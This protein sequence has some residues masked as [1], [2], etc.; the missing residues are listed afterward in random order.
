[1]CVCFLLEMLS[2]YKCLIIFLHLISLTGF[3]FYFSYS[4]LHSV[5]GGTFVFSCFSS[6][7]SH[8]Q[9][10]PPIFFFP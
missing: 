6:F 9:P 7:S 8:P 10:P 1:M 5:S 3:A 4:L 2:F